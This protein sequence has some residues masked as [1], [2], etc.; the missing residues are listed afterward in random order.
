[1]A[2]TTSI[3]ASPFA[4][5]P[6]A[7]SEATVQVTA[8]RDSALFAG[9]TQQECRMLA[10]SATRKTFESG[11]PL[12][13]EGKLIREV[14]LIES[15][16]VKLSK[17]RSLEGG[18]IL[19]INGRNKV[20]EIPLEKNKS[21]YACS[22]HAVERC[23]V[24]RWAARLL[25]EVMREYPQIRINVNNIMSER[26][27]ELEQRFRELTTEDIESRL[28]RTLLRLIS[29]IGR[30]HS[31]GVLLSVTREELAKISGMSM[32]TTSRLVSSWSDE[33]LI[34]PLRKA[35]VVRDPNQFASACNATYS[36]RPESEQTVADIGMCL[37][38]I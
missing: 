9:L 37:V 15:G 25:Y 17:L 4:G 26:L 11:K 8:M 30:D 22:A 20:L 32:F 35:I 3:Q 6:P 12:F 34:I 29:S 21:R 2:G 18:V 16:T 31:Q 38:S 1:M 36:S 33:N 10:L 14:M 28:A 23:S 24:L 19:W 13:M 27:R 5:K 7:D